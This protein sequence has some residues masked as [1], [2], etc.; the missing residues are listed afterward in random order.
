MRSRPGSLTAVL[1]AG[2]LLTAS[3]ALTASAADPVPDDWCLGTVYLGVGPGIFHNVMS[4]APIQAPINVRSFTDGLEQTCSGMTASVQKADGSHR[5]VVPLDQD[6][7]TTMP[8]TWT[9]LGYLT[10]PLSDGAGDWVITKITWGTKVMATDVHFRVLRASHLTVD[11]PVRTSG[12]ARTTITGV[13]QQY[14]G[15][16]ALAPSPNR[17]VSLVHQSGSPIATATS[18]AGGRYRATAAFTQNTTLR[19][20]VTETATVSSASTDFVTAHKLLAMS[21]LTA[22]TTAYVNTLW[23]VSGTAYPGKLMTS[24]EIFRDG[25]WH[26]AGSANY[27]AANGSYARYWKPNAAGTFRLRV[28]VSGPGLDNSPWSRDVAVTVRQLPQQP[29]Y[30][31]GLVAP[32]AGPPVKFGTKMSSFG[33]LKIRRSDGSRGPVANALVEVLAK[34]PGD[35]TWRK[36][37]GS[38][39]TSTGYFYNNWSVPFAAGETFTAVLRYTTTLPRAASSTSGTFGPFTVQP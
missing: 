26:A 25:A 37:S 18:D 30:L 29:T 8:P 2:L 21:Y 38:A 12:T 32:T 19:A 31:S 5:T 35:A 20:T 28:V 10:V 14:T 6:G 7:G 15:T 17:T 39:T 11:Q 22:A 1:L 9:K 16:G 27:T 13:L 24:L 23:K 33:F 3:G 4:N 36:V 34:R